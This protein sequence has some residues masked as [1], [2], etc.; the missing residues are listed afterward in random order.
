MISKVRYSYSFNKQKKKP[1]NNLGF[2]YVP[3]QNWSQFFGILI[4]AVNREVAPGSGRI[5]RAVLLIVNNALSFIRDAA[6]FKIRANISGNSSYPIFLSVI[7]DMFRK[8]VYNNMIPLPYAILN[9]L[10][11]VLTWWMVWTYQCPPQH[12]RWHTARWVQNHCSS[13]WGYEDRCW[14]RMS[15]RPTCWLTAI[16]ISSPIEHVNTSALNRTKRHYPFKGCIVLQ[17]TL[18]ST[19]ITTWYRH[20]GSIHG[21][22]WWTYRARWAKC[23]SSSVVTLIAPF[24]NLESHSDGSSQSSKLDLWLRHSSMRR[25]HE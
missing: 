23:L 18:G 10:T 7:I 14:K 25:D 12:D 16:N 22:L 15:C 6:K 21:D 2:W 17:T 9:L 3:S 20:Y 8:R 4:T 1:T 5:C 13:P 11:A 19:C 24:G